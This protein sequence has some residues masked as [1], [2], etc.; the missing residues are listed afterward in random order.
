MNDLIGTKWMKRLFSA[1]LFAT[2]ACPMA[3]AAE[4][5]VLSAGAVA[6][7]LQ[8]F[9]LLMQRETGHDMKIQFNT[10]PGIA[11]RL[12]A[13]EAYDILIAP[14]GTIDQAGKDGRV[15]VQSRVALGKVG[16]GVAVRTGVSAPAI[17]S[18]DALKRALLDADSVV[19]N[20]ASTGI[21]LD[22]L[23]EKMGILEQLKPKTIRY[24]DG[25]AVLEHVI[26][27][28]GNEI[29]FGAITEIR[30]Y[31][32]KG[33]QS[34]GPLPAEVQNYTSYEAVMMSRTAAPDAVR[35]V[36]GQLATPAAKAAFQS[37]GVE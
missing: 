12:A 9:A 1:M 14:P 32:A 24:P 21:Y 31:E 34:V 29:G 10:A 30:T 15:A 4:I 8:A 2:M 3:F 23:F 16:A 37:G 13:G 5:R 25:A 17:A 36:L 19:Y 35:T 27:G 6:P 26:K 20:T 33:L 28:N 18:V 11:K 7:E 22:K